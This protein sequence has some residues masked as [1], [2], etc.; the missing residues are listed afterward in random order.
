MDGKEAYELLV[1]AFD[2]H[3]AKLE[4]RFYGLN[5]DL[6]ERMAAFVRAKR[7]GGA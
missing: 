3:C 1:E 6:Y 2:D 4:E 5:A 7:L